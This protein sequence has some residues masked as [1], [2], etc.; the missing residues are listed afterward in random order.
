MG[1]AIKSFEDFFKNEVLAV[2]LVEEENAGEYNGSFQIGDQ[3]VQFG[4]E[5]VN[6]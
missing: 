4:L 1:E 5:R 6:I 3:K 2:E